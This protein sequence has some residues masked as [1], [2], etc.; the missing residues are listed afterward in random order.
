MEQEKKY[1]VSTDSGLD[2]DH[3]DIA[4]SPNSWVN[5]ENCRILSTDKGVIGTVESVG[6]TRALTEPVEGVSLI[7]I[8][9]A[10]D[11]QNRR[12]LYFL[13]DTEGDA[14]RIMC[15]D[16]RSAETYTVLLSTQVTG[17]L[18]FDKNAL[19]HS[20]R[21]INGL[22]YWTDNI[23]EPRRVNIDAGIKLNHPSYDT[24]QE[25]Y[26]D[27][28]D[29]SVITIARRPPGLPLAATKVNSSDVG[30]TIN[31]NNIRNSAFRFAWFYVYRDGEYST[32]SVHSI[33]APYN[34]TSETYDVIEL[35]APL[36]EYIEQDVQR[37]VFAVIYAD[38][39]KAFEIKTWDKANA[40]DA[41][42]IEDH[43][44]GIQP[45]TYYFT[46]NDVD[47]PISDAAKAKPFDSIPLLTETLEVANN[48]LFLGNNLLGY[49]TPLVTSL[50]ATP[51]NSPSSAMAVKSGSSRRVGIVFYDRYLRQCGVIP[52]LTIV[53]VPERNYEL[54]GV[55][56]NIG[57]TLSNTNALQE[58]PEWA[59][60]YSIVATKDLTRTFFVQAF[61]GNIVYATKNGDGNYEFTTYA[62][63][64]ANEGV[65]L[66]LNILNGYGMG[67]VFNEGDLVRVNVK[68]GNTETNTTL[69]VKGV[70]GDYL[71]AENFDFGNILYAIA[72]FEIYTPSIAASENFY[73]EQG[74]AY[75]I[76]NPGTSSRAY[77]TTSGTLRGDIYLQERDTINRIQYNVSGQLNTDFE[78]H[79]LPATIVSQLA[80]S[81]NYLAGNST[82]QNFPSESFNTNDTTW[83]IKTLGSA[84][85]FNFRGKFRFNFYD[86]GGGSNELTN[87]KI[88]I[89]YNDG[90]TTTSTTVVPNRS[91]VE[92]T[93]YTFEFNQDITVPANCRVFILNEFDIKNVDTLLRY[94]DGGLDVTALADGLQSEFE[95][96]SPNDKYYKNW[97]TDAGRFQTI[98]KI[99][100]RAKK[101]SIKWSNTFIPGTITNG[102]SSFDALDEKI[103]SYELGA[104][105]KLQVTSKV[106][107]EPGI[108]MLAICES[109]TA[110]MYLGEQQLVSNTGN[111]FVAQSDSVI[112]TINP[113]KGSFGTINPES[114]IEHRG[115]VYWV[116][117]LNGKMI[118]YSLN[119]LFP[120]SNYLMTRYWKQFSDQY[121][122]M[123][124]E[125][126]EALGSRPFIFTTVDPHHW[127]LLVA[128]PK[129]LETPPKGNLPDYP[130]MIYPFDIWD[131]QAK[132]L[133]YKLPIEPNRWLGAFSV[134]PEWLINFQNS[135]Y[136]FKNGVLYQLNDTE[137]Y[138]NFFGQQYK[139][140]IMFV[141]NMFPERPKVYKNIS[142][143]A[144][145]KPSLTYFYS[146]EPYEQSSDLLDTDYTVREGVFYAPLFRNKLVPTDSGYDI[147]G[148]LNG[149]E[150][151]TRVLKILMEWDVSNTPLELEKVNIGFQI[152]Y[153]HTT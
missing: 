76:S 153:G 47:T 151:R 134:T 152:S 128:V 23:N 86:A 149:E 89:A 106:N 121:T 130:S 42:A 147:T 28:I 98:D 120:I 92:G 9:A 7:C 137:T 75:P 69:S 53:T 144:N 78:L 125:E 18:N 59:Y 110:S 114:V 30:I 109:Q 34:A 4:I 56:Y 64:S 127:E 33:L 74:S 71:I 51:Q 90:S 14:D 82:F 60:Y 150:L 122:S 146:Q 73:Y 54:S 62:Y 95:C 2:A 129:L 101:T 97:F 123:T 50:M 100:Q 143:I 118:Q 32:L 1:F 46:N 77:S 126:I 22:L 145:L 55:F 96:M 13:K 25:P 99:G 19:I 12:I 68:V 29:P 140:R 37:V 67:Y 141:A 113:L 31:N 132:T 136:A 10:A 70:V 124:Q 148:L 131:G 36:G 44:D 117:V 38:G 93:V 85:N 88:F 41:A 24:D 135:V 119:G 15:Y 8:G 21:V 102:L 65:A 72:N 27:P 63:S 45:L 105:H 104:L 133:V 49:D 91:V 80:S 48:R 87:F 20:A 17:G 115:N 103:L 26:T 139:S 58:I 81:S 5:M 108:V 79:T 39:E 6:G 61:A 57:W 3:A 66:R 94:I 138:C 84:V 11:E 116:D 52:S 35:V 142:V 112:G 83:I 16:L 107:D 40:D 43:N 111:A